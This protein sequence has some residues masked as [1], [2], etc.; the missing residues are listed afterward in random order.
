MFSPT[1]S[2]NHDHPRTHRPL[3]ETTQM[4][5]KATAIGINHLAL[6]V[7][8]LEEA[9]ALYQ[10]L[11]EI[12]LRGRAPKMAF[13]DLGDQFIALE[14]TDRQSKDHHRH[15]GLVVDSVDKVRDAVT[16]ENLELIDGLGLD[17]RDPWGNRWQI[18]EYRNVQFSKADFVASAMGISNEKTEKAREELL[19]KG[20]ELP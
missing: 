7:G 3:P 20:Y 8:D 6:E 13:L 2:A 9:V 12:S 16:A 17:F 4:T 19:R 18:V 10:R 15:F 5:D 1:S 11:F 14:E